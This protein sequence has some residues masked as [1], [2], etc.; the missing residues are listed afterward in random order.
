MNETLEVIKSILPKD[1]DFWP[2]MA[3]EAEGYEAFYVGRNLDPVNPVHVPCLAAFIKNTE[4]IFTL[5]TDPQFP[6][7]DPYHGTVLLETDIANPG[8]IEEIKEVIGKRLETK[9]KI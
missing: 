1:I 5:L 8:S 9:S 2:T 3:H 4:I 6:I 7:A